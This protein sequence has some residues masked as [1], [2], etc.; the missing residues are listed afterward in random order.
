MRPNQTFQ[1]IKSGDLYT[2]TG[3]S[4]AKN[5][6]ELEDGTPL[7]TYRAYTGWY[8]GSL[9]HRWTRTVKEFS[10]KFQRFEVDA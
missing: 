10:E 6:P 5:M 2:I 1:H 4:F 7:I 9:A 8:G 3:L